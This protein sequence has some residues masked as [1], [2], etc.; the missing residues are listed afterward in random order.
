MDFSITSVIEQTSADH[1][2]MDTSMNSYGARVLT[3]K[4][5]KKRKARGCGCKSGCKKGRGVGVGEQTVKGP[6]NALAWTVRTRDRRTNWNCQQ[7]SIRLAAHSTFPA[8]RLF[9]G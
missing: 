7:H 5:T 9:K 8:Y 3:L 1:F 4:E 2:E 6:T